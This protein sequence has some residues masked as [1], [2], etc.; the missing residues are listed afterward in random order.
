MNNLGE[1]KEGTKIHLPALLLYI[2]LEYSMSFIL[3]K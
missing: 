1:S 2:L 3:S